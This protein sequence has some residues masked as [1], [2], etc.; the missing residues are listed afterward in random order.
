MFFE[1]KGLEDKKMLDGNMT[2]S[3]RLQSNTA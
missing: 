2:D 3:R 1:F